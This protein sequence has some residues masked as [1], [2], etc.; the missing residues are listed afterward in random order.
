MLFAAFC[1]EREGVGTVG[2]CVADEG[3]VV[4]NQRWLGDS[5]GEKLVEDVE[6]D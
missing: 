2:D 4:E 5:A 6:E 3:D 1:V